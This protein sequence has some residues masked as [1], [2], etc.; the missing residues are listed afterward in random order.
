MA[1]KA[2]TRVSSR[3]PTVVACR[4][5]EQARGGRADVDGGHGSSLQ[6]RPR[7]RA[8]DIGTDVPGATVG[9]PSPAGCHAGRRA[10]TPAPLARPDPGWCWG[11]RARFAVRRSRRGVSHGGVD[12]RLCVGAGPAGAR[13]PLGRSPCDLRCAPRR[14]A[15]LPGT[16][17]G[18]GMADS[19]GIPHAPTPGTSPVAV[20]CGSRSPRCSRPPPRRL[21]AAGDAGPWRRRTGR[22]R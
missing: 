6:P 22:N 9:R 2:M 17:E 20:L 12:I 5:A 19:P 10:V 7:S 16:G 4:P 11:A 18:Q 21:P 14:G 3:R 8:S 1:S 13:H 15:R